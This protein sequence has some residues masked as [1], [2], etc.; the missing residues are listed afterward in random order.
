MVKFDSFQAAQV[1]VQAAQRLTRAGSGYL[2]AGSSYPEANSGHFKDGW[3][4]ILM[5][6]PMDIQMDGWMNGWTLLIYRTS[7]PIG[8]AA[9]P[10]PRLGSTAY[11]R[12]RISPLGGLFWC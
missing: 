10:T 1:L 12:A 8:S 7:C 9:L 6:G 4:D 3:M 2:E 11:S 5:D